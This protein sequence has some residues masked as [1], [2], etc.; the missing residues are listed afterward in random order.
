MGCPFFQPT[1]AVSQPTHPGARLPLILEYNGL[2]HASA[3]G[4][5]VPDEMRFRCC[6]HGYSRSQCG[7]FP[8]A[9]TVSCFRYTVVSETP[10]QLEILC[11]EERDHTPVRWQRV[12]FDIFDN[13]VH[14]GLSLCARSQAEAFSRAY[15]NLNES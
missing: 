10:E 4:V 9:E 12:Q 14:A 1:E 6:N 13:R 15:L 7:H 5:P 2:C 3:A 11:V 8:V